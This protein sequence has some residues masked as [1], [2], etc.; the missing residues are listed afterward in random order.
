M[1]IKKGNTLMFFES[2][3]SNKK[4][5]NLFMTREGNIDNYD[6]LLVL[7]KTNLKKIKEFIEKEL[8]EASDKN[9]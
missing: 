7:N 3:N 1:K 5:W 9:G 2:S 4:N 6:L 8:K